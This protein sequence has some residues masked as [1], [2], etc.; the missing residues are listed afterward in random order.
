[1]TGERI[2][3]LD[4]LRGVAVM[5]IL[6]MNVT[7]FAMPFAAYDN[8]AAY[9]A[10][11]PI[12]LAV[13]AIDLI[14]ADGKFRAIFSALFGAGILL[15]AT[16]AAAAGRGPARAHLLRMAW[17]LLFG[18]VHLCLIWGG[19]I[20]TLYALIGLIAF[21]LR[22]LAADRLLIVAGLLLVVQLAILGAYYWS[23]G[24]LGRAAALPHAAPADVALWRSVLDDLGRPGAPALAR[25]LALHRGSWAGIADSLRSDAAIGLVSRLIL[26]GPETLGLML[27]GMAGL[28]S[29]FLAGD[30]SRAGYRRLAGWTYAIGLPPMLLIAFLLIR[31]G[32]P[33]LA[34]ATLVDLGALPFRW[35]IAA[36]HAALLILWLTRRP[37]P[38]RARIA[39]AGRAAFTNYLATSLIMT[40]LFYGWGLGL[41]GR[42]DRASLVPIVFTMWL[43]MLGWSKPWLDR[44]HHGPFE[45]L[46]RALAGPAP[47]PFRKKDIAS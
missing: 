6:L 40:G 10:M 41:Y 24:E 46:W 22:R 23:L 31:E 44:F 35:L 38:L 13:W 11:R 9:G 21:P 1:M 29:G 30:W 17:L 19:D 8:P 27:I 5:G 26:A 37:S 15:V 47:P 34:T 14:V 3:T 45:W 16:R 28:K 36:G 7:A 4:G 20:L 12:D 25:D 18:L 32:F 42:F 39:A 43:A 33:P 2:A